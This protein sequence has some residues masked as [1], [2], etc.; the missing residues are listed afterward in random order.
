MGLEDEVGDEDGGGG[1]ATEVAL[2]AKP[3]GSS[4]RVKIC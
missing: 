2:G 1:T 3:A 4:M